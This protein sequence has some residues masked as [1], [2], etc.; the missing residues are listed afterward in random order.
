M[1]IYSFTFKIMCSKLIKTFETFFETFFNINQMHNQV[2]FVSFVDNI[3]NESEM[4]MT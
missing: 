4:Y 2:F 1:K 3:E